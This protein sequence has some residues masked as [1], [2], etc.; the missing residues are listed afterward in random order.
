MLLFPIIDYSMPK[1]NN[2][3]RD[4]EAQAAI[5]DTGKDIKKGWTGTKP[6]QNQP[7][8]EEEE[9]HSQQATLRSLKNRLLMATSKSPKC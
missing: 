2:D 4:E 8:K 5:S 6:E 9:K 7:Q 1:E 3:D